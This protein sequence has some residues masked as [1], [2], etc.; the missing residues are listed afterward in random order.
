VTTGA[1]HQ[2]LADL[3]AEL[4]FDH[5]TICFG[6]ETTNFFPDSVDPARLAARL[7]KIVTLLNKRPELVRCAARACDGRCS[8]G[9]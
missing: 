7:R 2:H 4:E 3:E 1:A 8:H 9:R 6:P 5:V